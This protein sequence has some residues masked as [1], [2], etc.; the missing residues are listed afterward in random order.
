MWNMHHFDHGV[1]AV[2][3]QNEVVMDNVLAHDD[4]DDAA[5]HDEDADEELLD[6]PPMDDVLAH[7][8]P[9]DALPQGEDAPPSVN[10]GSDEELL[11][12]THGRLQRVRR[13]PERYID[14]QGPRG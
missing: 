11:D 12:Q 1:L 2:A 4:P 3:P 7:G 5:P 6:Q 10:A 14:E 9:D 8:E 13:K